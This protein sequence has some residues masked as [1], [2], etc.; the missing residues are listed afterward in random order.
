MFYAILRH[1]LKYWFKNPSISVYA[2]F[3]LV[4]SVITM[5]GSAGFFGEGS[6]DAGAIAN[7]PANLFS[8]FNLYGKLL[9]FLIPAIVG[10]AVYRDY[11]SNMQAVLYSYPFQKSDYLLGKFLSAFSVV[12]LISLTLGAGFMIGT[13]LPGIDS[14]MVL[15]LD[16]MT[17]VQLY[18]VYLLPNLLFAGAVVFGMVVFSRNIYAG[19]IAVVILLIVRE[20]A[21]RLI[22]GFD[23]AALTALLEPFG[24][25]ATALYTGDWS[26]AEKNTRPIPFQRI[27]LLNRVIWLGAAVAIFAITGK[28]FS[29]TQ[30]PFAFRFRKSKGERLLKRN[31]GGVL[32]IRL[33]AVQFDY[34]I[35]RQI[36]TARELSRIDFKYI[37][38]RGYFIGIALAGIILVTLLISQMDPP[39]Q[40]RV[41]PATWVMLAFPVFFISI[42]IN[43]AGFL[44]AGVLVHRS[45][46]H[47]MDALI[48]VTPLPNWVFAASQIIALVKMQMLLLLGTM[49]AGMAVQAVNGYYHFEIELYL[50]AL[51]GIHLISFVIWD[52]AAVFV[53]SIFINLYLGFFLLLV[54]F[55]GLPQLSQI[56]IASPVFQ[57]N[58]NP[59]PGFFLYYSDMNGYGHSLIPY[60]L[61]KL[62]WLIFGGILFCATLLFWIRGLPQSFKERLSIARS[63]LKPALALSL[64]GISA[65][66]LSMGFWLRSH[67]KQAEVL[68][69]K[70]EM[71]KPARQTEEKYEKYRRF[72]QPRVVAVEV[73][74]D[75]FPE[76]QS[77]RASGHYLLLNKSSTPIDTL[78]IHH[79]GEAI[80]HYRLNWG[81]TL[82]LS[83]SIAHLDI[84][85]LDESMEPGDSAALAFQVRNIPN[86]MLKKNSPVE[87][88]GTFITSSIFPEIGYYL[89][90][91]DTPPSDSA[92]LANHYRAIDADFVDL[93]LLISTSKDQ[94]IVASGNL[95]DKWIE[96]DRNY[97]K[98]V[99][100]GKATRDF[101]FCSA[102]YQVARDTWKNIDL[103]IYYHKGHRY[104]LASMFHGLKAALEY[105]ERHFGSYRRSKMK[106]AEFPRGLGNHAQSF[107]GVIMWS[108]LGFILEKQNPDALDFAFLGAAHE[109][110]HQWWGHQ[111]IP[112]D[113]MGARMITESMAEYI[114]LKVLEQEYG[115]QAKQNFLEMALELYLNKRKNDPDA[116]RPL[117]YNR[118]LDKKHIPYQ[119]GV[120]VMNAMNEYL[121]EGAFNAALG[122]YYRKVKLQDAPYTTSVEMVDFIRRGTPDSLQY[123][124]H[125]MFETV[126][127]Y[128][129]KLVDVKTRSLP[130]GEYEVEIDLVASKYRE[131]ADSAGY[132]D[133]A[134]SFLV[135][136][137]ENPPNAIKSLPLA[138][139][140]EIGL[141][142]EDSLLHLR[143]HKI[144]SIR[145]TLRVHV[146]AKPETCIIDPNFLLID[147]NRKDNRFDLQ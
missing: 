62:Y 133:E 93:E 84:L 8:L 130:N 32:G 19:F 65:A 115:L 58:Q 101:A 97:F 50:F 53:Q 16:L 73:N 143:K 76:S 85:K 89:D 25:V 31:F 78:L 95:E 44:F 15:P 147:K 116:E 131:E 135:F 54:G 83:G 124:I 123:L 86:A 129:N 14:R 102:R 99:S 64:C 77:F 24:E 66:F 126:T 104:N 5:A 67:E 87:K 96:R 61:Y 7:S 47:R 45:R 127:F 39:Y 57:F 138:D 92:A 63:R 10:H 68:P 41:I 23:S 120:L 137:P 56:G 59:E 36:K 48:D 30:H 74:I 43:L 70:K 142:G 80:T 118:G 90:Q 106:I 38:S 128:D 140:L 46:T 110:A 72:P 21:S 125:D 111:V 1:E 60:F 33:P 107:A 119:K 6:V 98:Y 108:E 109:M 11:K 28:K 69:S 141:Y 40:T 18:V 49:A 75:L 105:H 34:S 79:S 139:Y 17:Y 91:A 145:N 13:K 122:A 4:L 12:L 82:F 42:L 113:V 37:I 22:A 2:V 29:L 51:F 144:T 136:K 35:T 103:E 132:Q 9:L 146:K 88:N 121:G 134:G 3:F 52:I 27:I 100:R 114:A 26:A 20:I 112:A 94:T 71:Q 81:H 117:M 55:F